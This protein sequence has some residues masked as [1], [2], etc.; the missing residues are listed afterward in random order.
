MMQELA[1][2]LAEEGSD[3]DN[4]DVEDVETLQAALDRAVER[5][6]M[7]CSLRS[8][9]HGRWRRPRCD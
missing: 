1:P 4:L 3:V 9:K 5:R 7:A 6:N 8:A 2:L